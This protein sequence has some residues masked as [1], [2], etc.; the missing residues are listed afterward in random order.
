[1]GVPEQHPDHRGLT[2]RGPTPYSDPEMDTG[3]ERLSRK[4]PCQINE[5]F[6][7]EDGSGRVEP[8]GE[9]SRQVAQ[10]CMLDMSNTVDTGMDARDCRCFCNMVTKHKTSRCLAWDWQI[11]L[12][13]QPGVFGTIDPRRARTIVGRALTLDWKGSLI[14][15]QDIHDDAIRPTANTIPRRP[16]LFSY[17]VYGIQQERSPTSQHRIQSKEILKLSCQHGYHAGP[18]SST[19]GSLTPPEPLDQGSTGQ[20][21]KDVLQVLCQ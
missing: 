6:A 8:Q 4:G 21:R 16:T 12:G 5:E 3:D 9:G 10:C 14:C 19:L 2:R 17:R 1:M 15:N 18:Q 7:H 20:L 13:A 11:S